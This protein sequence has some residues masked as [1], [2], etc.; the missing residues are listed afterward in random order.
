MGKLMSV[1]R[2]A[3]NLGV[4]DKLLYWEVEKG[5]LPHYLVGSRILLD[6]EEVLRIARRRAD[7][8]RKF[9]KA[10]RKARLW[11]LGVG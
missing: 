6:P 9:V 11:A 1:D 7:E 10:R 2:V 3:K 5:R 8:W 4:S